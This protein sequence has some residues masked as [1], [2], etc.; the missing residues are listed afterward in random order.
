MKKDRKK[1]L[2]RIAEKKADRQNKR[3][4]DRIQGILSITQSGFGFV[5]PLPQKNA[6]PTEDI[7]IP[8]RY[9]N[10][11]IEGDLVETASVPPRDPSDAKGP[12][13]RIVAV[14]ERKKDS[15]VAELLPGN[16]LRPINRRL[17]EDIFL[18]GA[19]KGAKKGDW[20]KV[21]LDED[22]SGIDLSGTISKVIGKAGA[23]AADLDA[24]M[25]EFAISAPY[26]EAENDAAMQLPPREILRID[27]TDL[28]AITIDPADAKDF[29]DALSIQKG[30]RP[31]TIVIGVH[32]SDVAAYIQPQTTFDRA[33]AKRGFSCYLPGRTL[34]MLPPGLSAKISLQQGA[35]SLAHTVF[36]T[37][38][39]KTGKVLETFREHSFIKVAHRLDYDTVQTFCN[40][41]TAPGNWPP[42]LKETLTLLIDITR[43][44]RQYRFE[45]ESFIELPM[46]EIRVLCE[47]AANRIDGLSRKMSGEA[48]QLVEECMLAANSAVGR[49][50]V[51]KGIAGIFRI[52][53]VPETEN[54]EEFSAMVEEITGRW[55]GDLSNRN[56][57]NDFIGSLPDDPRK[58]VILSLL[59]RAM[60]RAVYSATPEIHF[61]LG[62]TRYCHFTS[63]IRRCPDLVVHQQLWNFD[64]NVRIRDKKTLEN[65]AAAFSNLEKANDDAFF[66]A[67]DRLKLRYLEQQLDAGAYNMYEGVVARVLQSGLQADISELGLYGFIPREQLPGEFRKSGNIMQQIHGKKTY[68]PGDYIYL[69]L[70]RIDYAQGSAVFVPAGR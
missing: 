18:H 19:R 52:H 5:R 28:D 64:R 53:Q 67:S 51:E 29:D 57:C 10:G 22:C 4:A 68:K 34:P 61:A 65:L 2:R 11:A 69:R 25:A 17:P 46:P 39:R 15:F 23:I 59:L 45:S 50:M 62:K 24:I 36:L 16:R 8:A 26:T 60:S 7:F 58:P 54:L 31:G 43:K 6:V 13:G 20:V 70:A 41:G 14:I 66:A 56:I 40:S 55:P 27:R 44:M 47:E 33:A 9:I 35:V 38:D 30:P 37:V 48:E 49:E 32:I 12:V 63:P 3:N 21:Q 1:R 42:A